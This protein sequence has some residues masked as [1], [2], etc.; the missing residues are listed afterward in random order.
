MI[1]L[2][3]KGTEREAEVEAVVTT[4]GWSLTS[5]TTGPRATSRPRARRENGNDHAQGL[6]GGIGIVI[7][8]DGD[9][10]QTGGG[11]VMYSNDL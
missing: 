6:L 11:D 8:T 2:L 3:P 4:S 9:V 10:V 1:L 7:E 5:R